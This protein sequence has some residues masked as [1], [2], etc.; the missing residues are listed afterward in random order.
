MT[1]SS[2]FRMA[3]IARCGTNLL[4]WLVMNSFVLD[5]SNPSWPWAW[6]LM[7]RNTPAMNTNVS[8]TNENCKQATETP[9]AC[10]PPRRALDGGRLLIVDTNVQATTA[11][12]SFGAATKLEEREAKRARD[13]GNFEPY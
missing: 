4:I 8:I 3:S 10:P 9:A 2:I 11:A 12:E 1:S 7:N 6:K 5:C 13:G